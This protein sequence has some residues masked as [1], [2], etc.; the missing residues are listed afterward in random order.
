MITEFTE[1]SAENPQNR[2]NVF[3]PGRKKSAKKT[4]FCV[5]ISPFSDK[6]TTFA[7]CSIDK[8]LMEHQQYMKRRVCAIRVEP[9]LA[10]YA[11]MKFD[12]D[13]KT[14]G[15]RIPDSFDLYHCVWQLMERRPVGAELPGEPNLMIWLPA[16]RGTD[17]LA[18]K[19]PAFW[20]YLSP[21]S[22]RQVERQLRQLFNWEFHHYMDMATR[23][24][25][26]RTKIQAVRS[27]ISKY[28]LGL[29]CEDALLK[30]IQRHERTIQV[31]LGIKKGENK[32]KRKI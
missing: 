24:E 30:N 11:K 14:G 27:F 26:R 25:Q 12:V 31:F 29:D 7:A 21:R 4:H 18:Q 17:G 8:S 13:P 15:I 32:K 1:K 22:A 10:T 23:G 20:N 28:S 2:K 19:N 9:Y 3:E 16:R 5:D 6:I